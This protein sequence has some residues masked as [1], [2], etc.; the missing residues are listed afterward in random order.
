ME[1]FNQK[2]ANELK[3]D[4]NFFNSQRM[5]HVY[6]VSQVLK[7]KDREKQTL[8]IEFHQRLI[9]K[10]YDKAFNQQRIVNLLKK[11]G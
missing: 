6:V 4:S 8:R 7:N 10:K 1:L 9:Q 11:E 5:N 3:E 2:L